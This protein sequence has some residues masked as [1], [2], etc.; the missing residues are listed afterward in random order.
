[1]DSEYRLPI[2]FKDGWVHVVFTVDREAGEILFA[3]DFG[4]LVSEKLSDGLK[5]AS[6]DSLPALNIGQDGTGKYGSSL[7][8][9][10]TNFS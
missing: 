3:Y 4:K 9:C 5:H 7:T 1:M 2:D 10:S 8:P 6:F